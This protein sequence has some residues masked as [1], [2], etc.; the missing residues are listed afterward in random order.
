M[1]VSVEFEDSGL[2]EEHELEKDPRPG[3][4]INLTVSGVVGQYLVNERFG[5]QVGNQ[6]SSPVN[7]TVEK[8]P[9]D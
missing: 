7:I 8:V 6:P 1:K 4:I 5:V 2:I 9:K 3:E